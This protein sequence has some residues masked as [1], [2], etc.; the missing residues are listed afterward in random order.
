[1]QMEWNLEVHGEPLMSSRPT[2]RSAPIRV[3]LVAG[4][5]DGVALLGL[6]LAWPAAKVVV[7]VDPLP[8]AALLQRAQSLGIPS[9]TRHLDVLGHLPV[10]V[11]VDATGHTPVLEEFLRTRPH[12]IEVIRGESLSMLRRL[13]R[14]MAE[15]LDQQ[16]ATSEIFRVISSSPTDVQ[17][18]F[19]A[20]VESAVRLC[21]GVSATVYRFDGKLIHLAAQNRGVTREAYQAFERRYPA[22]PSRASVVTEAILNRTVIH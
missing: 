16:V 8:G 11:I 22:P 18:V 5:D 15:S 20:I 19:L 21:D 17:P 6:L 13:L 2:D 14:D 10:D 9:A 12:D 3:G 1:M 4:G 7:V